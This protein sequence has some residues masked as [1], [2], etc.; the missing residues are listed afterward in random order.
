MITFAASTSIIG[1]LILSRRRSALCETFDESLRRLWSCRRVEIGHDALLTEFEDAL[2]RAPL[3]FVSKSMNAKIWDKLYDSKRE[4]R[5]D[6]MTSIDHFVWLADG[7]EAWDVRIALIDA[8]KSTIRLQYAYVYLDKYGYAFCER[9]VSA[10]KRGV[11]VEVIIDEFGAESFRYGGENPRHPCRK[12]L[13]TTWNDMISLMISNGVHVTYWHGIVKDKIGTKSLFPS[14]NHVK[15]M[16]VDDTYVVIGDRN[17]GAEYFE[18]WAGAD[19]LMIGDVAKKLSTSFARDN[20]GYLR[21]VSCTTTTNSNT[22]SDAERI[23]CNPEPLRN[24]LTRTRSI[25]SKTS[26]LE[27]EILS[28]IPR[29]DGYDSILHSIIDAVRSAKS[30]VCIRSC[31][32][33]LCRPLRDALSVAMN[34]RGVKVRILTN[35]I[36][37]NDLLFIHASMCQSL[38]ELAQDGAVVYMTRHEMDHTKF[39]LIDR[40]WICVGSWNAW[41]R[42]HFYESELNCVVSDKN[43][44]QVIGS[45][46]FDR[47]CSDVG[48]QIYDR[49]MLQRDALVAAEKFGLPDR[50]HK[51]FI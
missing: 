12:N 36:D 40:E 6:A 21:E 41:L 43:L 22:S 44:G 28:H 47:P 19:V 16:I 26:N 38:A 27:A 30:E 34:K 5:K 8:A 11:K 1:T 25:Q 48:V 46:E 31:Y 20:V 45:K 33:V 42:T 13:K 29:H 14:K 4:V 39:I 37:T 23:E 17:I 2:P 18:E 49:N 15:M 50:F 7:K 51:M 24:F 32:V 10:S 35:S 3:D 9:L